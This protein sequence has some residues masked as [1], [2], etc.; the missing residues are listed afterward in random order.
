MNQGF[1]A[2]CCK[3]VGLKQQSYRNCLKDAVSGVAVGGGDVCPGL[4]AVLRR[5]RCCEG[6]GRNVGGRLKF[7]MCLL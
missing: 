2:V 4:A 1:R 3:E 5:Q 7:V 6:I